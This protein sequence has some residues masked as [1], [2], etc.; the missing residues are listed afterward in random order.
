MKILSFDKF[1]MLPSGTIFSYYTPCMCDGLYRKGNSIK[2]PDGVFRDY[3]E[4]S[5]TPF[6][7]QGDD[8]VE[9]AIEGRWGAFEYDQLYAVLEQD[10]IDD[11][12]SILTSNYFFSDRKDG[13]S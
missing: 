7:L 1:V 8:P 9:S 3:F 5:V 4:A 2:H 6:C 13:I 12:I 10:D 11:V